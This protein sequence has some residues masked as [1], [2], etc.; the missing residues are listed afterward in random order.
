MYED[1]ERNID[2][3]TI[4]RQEDNLEIV[5]TGYSS[6]YFATNKANYSMDKQESKTAGS[7]TD[8]GDP[9]KNILFS[10]DLGLAVQRPPNGMSMEQLWKIL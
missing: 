1:S 10:E 7:G 5:D 4:P 2:A 6:T 3:V 9:L 8:D